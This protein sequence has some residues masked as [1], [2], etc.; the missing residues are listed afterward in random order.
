MKQPFTL[1]VPIRFRQGDPA[2]ISFFANVYP[3]AHDAFEDFVQ[4]L[5]FDWKTW[6]ANE[7]WGV[8][9]RHS[10]CEYYQP[11][12]PGR[13]CSITVLVD[14]VG[15][16]S[17]TL[18]YIFKNKD[19]VACEVTLVH[20]FFKIKERAKMPIPSVVRDGLETYQRECLNP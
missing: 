12:I 7:E 4:S 9:I 10:S 19:Q 13:S 17:A 3:M 20:T 16:S 8:P 2:G 6:F 15:E 1:Q 11:L 18:K 5:G 14:R